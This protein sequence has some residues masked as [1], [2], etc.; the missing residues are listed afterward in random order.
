MKQCPMCG[1]FTITQEGNIACDSCGQPLVV[2]ASKIY[3]LGEI[4]MSQQD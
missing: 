1:G 2:K 4:H 3:T